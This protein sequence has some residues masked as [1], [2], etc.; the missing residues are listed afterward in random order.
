M[1]TD[2]YFNDY[3]A[4]SE[5]EISEITENG[6]ALKNGM[7]IDFA[8]CEEVSG[9]V[10]RA[11]NKRC[12]GEREAADCSFTFYTL[13]KPIMIKFIPKEKQT[14]LFSENDAQGRFFELQKLID[15][16]GYKTYDIP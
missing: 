7:Y 9:K 11:Q 10:N 4:F 8:V 3:E 1:I 16:F 13:P 2:G 15:E 12:I 14:E 6:I 5:N